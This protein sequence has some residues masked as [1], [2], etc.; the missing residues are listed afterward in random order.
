MR[1]QVETIR[2]GQVRAYAD[3]VYEYHIVTVHEVGDE[4]LWEECQEIHKTG[5]RKDDE[6]HTGHCGFPFGLNSFGSLVRL[7]PNKWRYTVTEP[8]TG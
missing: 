8:Y 6:K 4:R 2:A 5:Y 1:H 7:G 3:S